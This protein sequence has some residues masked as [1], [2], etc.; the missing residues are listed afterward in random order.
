MAEISIDKIVVGERLRSVDPD[1]A[2]FLA[3]SIEENG[4][5]QPVVVSPDGQGG[6]KLVDGAHRLEA[7]RILG[8]AKI[9][10]V[11]L[12]RPEFE[13]RLMEI[14]ANLM[15]RELSPLHIGRFLAER[16]YIVESLHGK[17]L[18][19]SGKDKYNKGIINM[20]H[21]CPALG[22]RGF[23]LAAA[24]KMRVTDRHI[25]RFLGVH[26]R[27]AP[28]VAD[29]L[30]STVWSTKLNELL[31][32]SR[33][34]PAVQRDICDLLLASF[35]GAKSVADA[36]IALGLRPPR[37]KRCQKRFEALTSAW[38]TADKHTKARFLDWL[39]GHG[40]LTAHFRRSVSDEPP[41]P[42][43][44]PPDWWDPSREAPMPD[45][46]PDAKVISTLDEFNDH[47]ATQ[48]EATQQ[49]YLFNRAKYE[50]RKGIRH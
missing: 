2:K 21:A 27:L 35:G 42:P 17:H 41:V 24:E 36:L 23:D 19:G 31:A 12:Q 14:D 50:A 26:Q 29:R 10:A 18:V 45:I 16:R 40:H 48:D 11:V 44:A 22:K 28:D 9:R 34:A 13:R 4:L 15:R 5:L 37:K 47:L 30:E 7:H 46:D 20:G 33:E 39:D 32:L 49:K 8:L 25:R 43:L 3:S 38:H 6:Y 1:W